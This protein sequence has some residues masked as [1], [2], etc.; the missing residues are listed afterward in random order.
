MY[1]KHHQVYQQ[2]HNGSSRR[3]GKSGR[4]YISVNNGLKDPKFDEVLESV[5]PRRLTNTKKAKLKGI[6]HW[7]TLKSNYQKT[8]TKNKP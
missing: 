8:T 3:R 5:N 1:V 7:D 2:M 6:P 4:K